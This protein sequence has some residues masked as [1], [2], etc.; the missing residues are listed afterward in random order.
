MTLGPTAP[1]GVGYACFGIAWLLYV[2]HL[3]RKDTYLGQLGTAVQ[4]LG[5][6]LWLG[7]WIWQTV[8]AGAWPPGL[9][10]QDVVLLW[11]PACAAVVLWMERRHRT[12]AISAFALVIVLVL[13]GLALLAPTS[14]PTA[15]VIE[16]RSLW[17]LAYV[18][19]AVAGYSVLTVTAAVGVM[20]LTPLLPPAWGVAG[21]LPPEEMLSR[22]T[23]RNVSWGLLILSLAL[24]AGAGW[25]W[26]ADGQAWPWTA[27]QAWMLAVWAAY[28]AL[29]HFG[30]FR[31][32][33]IANVLGLVLIRFGALTLLK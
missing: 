17:E 13:G 5:A 32:W 23:R 9:Q 1:L 24:A 6:V 18:I 30:S 4:A 2:A 21:R 29:L 27:G 20:G 22:V 3:V 16:R 19:L 11:V 7:G 31:G 12:H 25:F 33:P 10:S 8:R 28:S 15:P 26:L 14:A